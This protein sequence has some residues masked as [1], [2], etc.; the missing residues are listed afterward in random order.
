MTHI[1][2]E[3]NA[4]PVLLR[5]LHKLAVDIC[6]ELEQYL[7]RPSKH[8][9][10]VLRAKSQRLCCLSAFA[11]NKRLKAFCKQFARCCE[12]LMQPEAD[13]KAASKLLMKAGLILAASLS[14]PAHGVQMQYLAEEV[15]D[16]LRAFRGGKRSTKYKNKCSGKAILAMFTPCGS[17]GT[18]LNA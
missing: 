9:L 2:T 10:I 8:H 4:L 6:T 12:L 17:K 13:E 18:R 1:L 7:Q 14:H 5:Q 15:F 11:G 16:L 3:E